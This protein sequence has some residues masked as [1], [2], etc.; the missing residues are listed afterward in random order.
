MMFTVLRNTSE[1]AS[2]KLERE[3][4][5]QVTKGKE[6]YRLGSCLG[7]LVVSPPKVCCGLPLR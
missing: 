6:G 3:S 7:D 5:R 2:R 4:K 1:P